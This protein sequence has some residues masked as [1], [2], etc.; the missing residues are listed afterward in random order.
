MLH[1]LCRTEKRIWL[2]ARNC[3][4]R[5]RQTS[6]GQWLPTGGSLWCRIARSF[7]FD[8]RHIGLSEPPSRPD[9]QVLSGITDTTRF[10]KIPTMLF[11][12]LTLGS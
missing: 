8:G 4:D 10:D 7:C 9:C 11:A 5:Y 3:I 1:R 6:A 12:I 2:R